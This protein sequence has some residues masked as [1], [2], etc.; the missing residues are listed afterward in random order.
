[1]MFLFGQDDAFIVLSIIFPE[2]RLFFKIKT[3]KESIYQ[4]PLGAFINF[5]IFL[6]KVLSQCSR[7]MKDL[8][9]LLHS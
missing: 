1:M 8:R 2:Q 9:N 4:V 7:V 5:F 3:P 6:P